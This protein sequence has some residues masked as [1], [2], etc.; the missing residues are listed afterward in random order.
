MQPVLLIIIFW[1]SESE[2]K[3]LFLQ[4]QETFHFKHLHSYSNIRLPSLIMDTKAHVHTTSDRH[5]VEGGECATQ[6]R[7]LR[8]E[9]LTFASHLCRCN[10]AVKSVSLVVDWSKVQKR[11]LHTW[12][13]NFNTPDQMTKSVATWTFKYN[14]MERVVKEQTIS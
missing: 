4:I 7:L 3:T 11:T 14:I 6:W 12:K 5:R 2:I 9:I 13:E 1:L 8:L 10:S